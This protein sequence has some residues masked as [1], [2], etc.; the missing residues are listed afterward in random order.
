MDENLHDTN[1]MHSDRTAGEPGGGLVPVTHVSAEP[2]GRSVFPDGVSEV[3]TVPTPGGLCASATATTPP[4][5]PVVVP[6][7]PRGHEPAVSSPSSVHY[8]IQALEF[9][10][11]IT[12]AFASVAAISSA[13]QEVL[14]GFPQSGYGSHCL[15]DGAMRLALVDVG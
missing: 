15:D 13:D 6:P 1:M 8:H 12:T 4:R 7:P 11:P 2:I 9:G 10:A 14:I 3:D 5:V